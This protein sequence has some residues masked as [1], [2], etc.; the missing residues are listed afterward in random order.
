MIRKRA[1]IELS[2]IICHLVLYHF[3]HHTLSQTRDHRTSFEAKSFAVKYQ[4]SRIYL[5][6]LLYGKNARPLSTSQ[7]EARDWAQAQARARLHSTSILL[8]PKNRKLLLLRIKIS[9]INVFFWVKEI[10][11][12]LK[13]RSECFVSKLYR[14]T[15]ASRIDAFVIVGIDAQEAWLC[16]K[17]NLETCP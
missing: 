5:F 17:G 2:I 9:A 6:Y 10:F 4:F 14:S 13:V 8:F 12:N 11:L 3:S 1:G 16:I 15:L 7:S